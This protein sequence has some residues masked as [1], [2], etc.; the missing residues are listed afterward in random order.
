[1]NSGYDWDFHQPPDISEHSLAKHEVYRSY[2][3]RYLQELTK[4]FGLDRFRINIVDGFAGG[5]IYKHPATGEPY[6]GSPIQLLQVLEELQ[7]ELQAKQEKPFV[8]DFVVHLVE[9]DKDAL[10]SLRLTI[11]HAGFGGY[12]NTKLFIY[13]ETFEEAL[14]TIQ[15]RVRSRGRTI[16]ILDQYGYQQVPFRLLTEIFKNLIRPEV[17]LTFAYDHLEGFVQEYGR[18]SKALNKLGVASISRDDY[19]ASMAIRGGREFFIQRVLHKAFLSYAQYYTPFFIVSRKSNLAFWLV[20]LSMHARARDVMTELHWTLQN[21]FSHYGGAGAHM[22]GF[23]PAH[24]DDRQAF[25][26][27]DN[28]R[29]RTI[30]SLR[31]Q[32]PNL[33][34]AIGET[35]FGT[36]Y[37]RWANESPATSGIFAEVVGELARDR[38]II[39]TTDAGNPKRSFQ[40]IQAKDRLSLSRQLYLPIGKP[41]R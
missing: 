39:L 11:K 36:F 35:E 2:L 33:L 40:N 25:L 27:D 22:L 8:L 26:F 15:S 14:P 29:T 18:L 13:E 37:A 9:A 17:I 6:F 5:G 10:N 20:H 23:D 1:M 24:A 41:K 16:F 3:R 34:E 19:Q 28:A 4:V 32:V 38:E 31:E 30:D 7:I 21:H 12:E